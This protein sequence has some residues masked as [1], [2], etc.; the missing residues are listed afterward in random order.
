MRTTLSLDDDIEKELR[1]S[2]R[3]EGKSFREIVNETLRRGLTS[4]PPRGR[5]TRR[6]RVFPKA[7][8]FRA[9]IDLTKLNQL[10]DDFEIE[11][12]DLVAVRDR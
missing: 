7:C 3:R 2:A 11:R 4:G 10:I 12:A 6:F 8:G 5:R 1:N 9:G